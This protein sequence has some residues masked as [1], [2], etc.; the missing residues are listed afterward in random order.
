MPRASVCS[1]LEACTRGDLQ[2]ASILLSMGIKHSPQRAN[3]SP[4]TRLVHHNH[5]LKELG[6][7]IALFVQSAAPCQRT[8]A[9]IQFN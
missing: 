7:G 1:L 2:L 8:M 9:R 6:L 3:H 5:V 4:F